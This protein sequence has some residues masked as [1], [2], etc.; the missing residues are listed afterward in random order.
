MKAPHVGVYATRVAFLVLS[1]SK[2]VRMK[3]SGT[4]FTMFNIPAALLA[5]ILHQPVQVDDLELMSEFLIL[6]NS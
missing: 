3:Y 1:S 6:A 4:C 2:Y 5:A